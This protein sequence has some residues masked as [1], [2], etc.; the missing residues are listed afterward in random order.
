[1]VQ[2]SHPP[3]VYIPLDR[4]LDELEDAVVQWKRE[5][6]FIEAFLL[7]YPL[8]TTTEI[9]ISRILLN[10]TASNNEGISSFVTDWI[11]NYPSDFSHKDFQALRRIV[12]LDMDDIGNGRPP[13]P[14]P[15]QPFEHLLFG[16]TSHEIA[17]QITNFVTEIFE[18]IIP[19]HYLEQPDHVYVK[20]LI[21]IHER[22]SEE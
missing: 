4:L 7:T 12:E 13:V 20:Q 16:K 9:V 11:T 5:H 15:L 17:D 18:L 22:I 19:R 10:P 6:A 2:L 14:S 3:T 21:D 8:F 1:M